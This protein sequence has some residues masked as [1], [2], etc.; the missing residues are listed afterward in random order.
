[1][2][3]DNLQ[4]PDGVTWGV[5]DG[6]YRNIEL[7]GHVIAAMGGVTVAVTPEDQ[8]QDELNRVVA[9]GLRNRAILQ[10]W[11]DAAAMGKPYLTDLI[12]L[13]AAEDGWA[14]ITVSNDP[15]PYTPS[16]TDIMMTPLRK[17]SMAITNEVAGLVMLGH[18]VAKLVRSDDAAQIGFLIRLPSEAKAVE[19]V[20]G[21]PHHDRYEVRGA[22]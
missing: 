15:Q 9:K 7:D 2:W 19:F 8:L 17:T 11:E 22:R 21:F 3:C 10:R 5:W 14:E 20:V 18:D 1:M 12:G 6:D 13:R 4:L 16:P